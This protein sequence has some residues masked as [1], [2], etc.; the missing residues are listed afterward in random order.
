MHGFAR[1]SEFDVRQAPMRGELKHG[2]QS[3]ERIGH[4]ILLSRNVMK[5]DIIEELCQ[6]LDVSLI[7]YQLVIPGLPFSSQLMDH[8]G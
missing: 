4:L 7:G 8:Q 5:K 6:F 2:C 1:T 3:G